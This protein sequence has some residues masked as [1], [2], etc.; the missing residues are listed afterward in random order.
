MENTARVGS[1]SPRASSSSA[2]DC[3]SP[4][5]ALSNPSADIAQKR[6]KYALR[7]SRRTA[8]AEAAAASQRVCASES[9]ADIDPLLSARRIQC[10]VGSGGLLDSGESGSRTVPVYAPTA[11]A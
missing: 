6:A 7:G 1:A 4:R 9:G 2:D 5:R 3:G 11:N 8:S 10:V